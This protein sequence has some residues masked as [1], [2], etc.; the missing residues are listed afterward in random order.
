MM[1]DL[2]IIWG[3]DIV[4]M[5]VSWVLIPPPAL[6]DVNT[7]SVNF[8]VGQQSLHSQKQKSEILLG[9]VGCNADTRKLRHLLPHLL[10]P[11][12]V[13]VSISPGL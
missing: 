3:I 8:Q 12:I 5:Q 4:L 2:F 11:K 13:F 1:V 9:E 6:P 7:D 10:H